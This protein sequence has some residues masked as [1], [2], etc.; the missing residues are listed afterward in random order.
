MEKY[1]FYIL[2]WNRQCYY[3]EAKNADQNQ[4][5]LIDSNNTWETFKKQS[6]VNL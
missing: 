4:P 3:F 1:E 2:V 5:F 6:A